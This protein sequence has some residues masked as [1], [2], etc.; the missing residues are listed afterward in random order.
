MS[1]DSAG[2]VSGAGALIRQVREAQSVSIDALASIIK[3]PV[4]KLEALEAEDWSFLPDANLNRALAMT[5]CRAL[6]VEAAPIMAL[7]PAAVVKSLAAAKAPL[8]QPFRDFSHTG[9]TFESSSPLGI[10]V[11][12]MSSAVV[13]PV[14]LLLLAAGVYF[15]PD[16]LDVEAW[17]PAL[18]VSDAPQPAVPASGVALGLPVPMPVL[19]VASAVSPAAVSVVPAVASAAAAS[20]APASPAPVASVAQS[21]RTAPVAASAVVA[22]PSP[23]SVVPSSASAP[24]GPLAK[25][26]LS[27]K[28][29]AWIE[30]RDASGQKLFSRLLAGGERVELQGRPPLNVHAGNAP[31]VSIQFNGRPVDLVAVTRQNVARIELK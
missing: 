7:M 30:V 22:Q 25:M 23:A 31:T 29:S 8:N 18:S 11:P 2:G 3:V 27:A 1:L 14:V 4:A 5:V 28:E 24:S 21:V 17:F 12:K 6:K 19:E 20:S 26:T 10:R 15:A 16:Q 13:G 9:L